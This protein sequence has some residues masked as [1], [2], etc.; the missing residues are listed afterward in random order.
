MRIL[1]IAD[2]K[3][4]IIYSNN[5]KSRFGDVDLVLSAGDLDLEYY[6]FIVSTI[7]KPLYFVFGNHNLKHICH[8]RKEYAFDNPELLQKD[9][10]KRSFG[11]IYTGGKVKRFKNLLIAG[12]GGSRR[13]NNGPNQFTEF[14]MAMF[15]LR[16]LPGLLWNKIRYGRF[17][18]IFLTHS[19][20][21]GFHDKEDL[22]HQGFK[23]YERFC[24]LFKP[25]YFIHGHVHLWDKNENR[26]D[27]YHDTV[28]INAYDHYLLDTEQVYERFFPERASKK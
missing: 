7:N 12:V 11:S 27:A 24:K 1:C 10:I 6:G 16:L 14:G 8:Y 4:P 28:L 2:H 9:Y 5:L 13:Y 21:R 15:M 20:P 3:D 25:R 26:V 17:L 22:C 18:D 19:P 23:I